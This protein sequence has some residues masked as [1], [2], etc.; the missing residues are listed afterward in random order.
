[1]PG[2]VLFIVHFAGF[3]DTFLS[4]PRRPW[5]CQVK[6]RRSF[7]IKW[8]LGHFLYVW[9]KDNQAAGIFISHQHTREPAEKSSERRGNVQSWKNNESQS[10]NTFGGMAV[11]KKILWQWLLLIWKR[12]SGWAAGE[13]EKAESDKKVFC[14]VRFNVKVLDLNCMKIIANS[15]VKADSNFVPLK[16]AVVTMQRHFFESHECSV[17]IYNRNL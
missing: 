7:L 16:T 15:N 17:N 10:E 14:S 2:I 12:E 5:H 1:M 6:Q 13:C 8:L 4:S 3:S 9:Q 11:R